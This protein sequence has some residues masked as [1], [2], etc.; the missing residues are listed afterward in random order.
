MKAVV[1]RIKAL[2][3]NGFGGEDMAGTFIARRV[4]PLQARTHKIRFMG[5]RLDS[6]WTSTFVLIDDELQRRTKAIANT[7]MTS[8]DWGKSPSVGGSRLPL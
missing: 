2:E 7:R 4:L 5:S 3:S 1:K 6:T 8:W